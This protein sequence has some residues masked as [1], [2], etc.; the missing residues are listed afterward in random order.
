MRG[1]RLTPRAVAPGVFDE[2]LGGM[3]RGEVPQTRPSTRPEEPVVQFES[4]P[5]PTTAPG[6]DTQPSTIHLP[7]R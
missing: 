6:A 5:P 2:H 3:R 4:A 7:G 1:T